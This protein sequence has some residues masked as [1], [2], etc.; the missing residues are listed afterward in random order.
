MNRK[1]KK[2]KIWNN[3]LKKYFKGIA[4]INQ[5]INNFKKSI[6]LS[7]IVWKV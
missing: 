2:S 7:E 6:S 1:R 3:I 5:L 4:N